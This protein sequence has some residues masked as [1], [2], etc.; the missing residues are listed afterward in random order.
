MLR[1]IGIP[2]RVAT[3]FTP[4]T[5]VGTNTY[6][7]STDDLHAWVEVPFDGYGWLPFEPTPGT[8]TVNPEMA[9]YALLSADPTCSG[10]NCGDLTNPGDTKTPA[11]KPNKKARRACTDSNPLT[12]CGE[13][14]GGDSGGGLDL[15]SQGGAQPATSPERSAPTAWILAAIAAAI[16][17]AVLAGIPLSRWLRRRRAL[18]HAREPRE[19]ILATYDVFSERAADLGLGRGAGETPS[20][21]R[22]RIEGT[23]LL[24]DGHMERLTGTVV[25]A[26]YSARPMTNDDALDATADADQVIRDLR[27]STSLR[28]RIV[29]IYRRD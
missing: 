12:I 29:G 2:A 8:S 16:A 5:T 9:T 17:L 1:T 21:Y 13:T 22:R 27:R 11:P 7:V 10:P 3:G 14:K 26:A 19:L 20:E 18:T 6:D 28:R 15:G 24:S 25:R 4:G 23:D